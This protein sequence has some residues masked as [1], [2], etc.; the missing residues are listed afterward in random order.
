ME[1]YILE[2]KH[3]PEVPDAIAV[4]QDGIEVGEMNKILLQK[5]EEMTLYLIELEKKV[6]LLELKVESK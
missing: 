5:M 1:K 3:L 2:H 4:E 6:K